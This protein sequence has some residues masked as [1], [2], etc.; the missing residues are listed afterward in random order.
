MATL[1]SFICKM[2]LTL[3]GKYAATMQFYLLFL[4][5]RKEKY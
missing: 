4:W 3:G 5:S 1:R 2:L